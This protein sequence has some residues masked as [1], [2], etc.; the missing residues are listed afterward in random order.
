MTLRK[1]DIVRKRNGHREKPMSQGAMSTKGDSMSEDT[2]TADVL[3]S[4][5]GEF[6]NPKPLISIGCNHISE[7]LN[8]KPLIYPG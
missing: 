5:R 8:H 1:S 4:D 3:T 6:L 2:E 7:F